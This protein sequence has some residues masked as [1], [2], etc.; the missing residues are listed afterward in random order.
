[1]FYV[2]VLILGCSQLIVRALIYKRPGQFASEEILYLVI[3]VLTVFAVLASFPREN[4]EFE[5]PA[6]F[7]SD[8]RNVCFQ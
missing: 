4:N 8:P 2:L 5:G 1:M 7:F 3:I 6:G